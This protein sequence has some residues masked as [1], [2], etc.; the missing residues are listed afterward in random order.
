MKKQIKRERRLQE[1][2]QWILDYKGKNIVKGYRKRFQ[3]DFMCAISEL[4]MLGC[5]F[6]QEYIRSVKGTIE[7]E[8]K[9]R[10]NKK[11]PEKVDLFPD[12]DDTFYYIAGHT[13]GG[14]PFG[15][16]WA[17]MG[18]EPYTDVEDGVPYDF[19]TEVKDTNMIN[20]F[21]NPHEPDDELPF[22]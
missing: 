4:Q 5:K 20:K 8:K 10:E 6:S 9:R 18:L 21:D 19:F 22:E 1:A 14:A 12:S 3:L 16:T 13:S 2:K 7:S 15:L 17:E 11:S